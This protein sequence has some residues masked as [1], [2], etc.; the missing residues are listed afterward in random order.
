MNELILVFLDGQYID[1]EWSPGNNC[2]DFIASHSLRLSDC[3]PIRETLPTITLQDI[4][5]Q[6]PLYLPHMT[7]IE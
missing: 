5:S 1:T 3:L 2:Q 4:S 7:D 6:N